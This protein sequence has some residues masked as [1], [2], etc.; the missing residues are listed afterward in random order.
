MKTSLPLRYL[1][2]VET[3]V[4]YKIERSFAHRGSAIRFARLSE[5]IAQNWMVLDLLTPAH[6]GSHSRKVCAFYLR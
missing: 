4:G 5:H 2:K 3:Q 6:E 1:A